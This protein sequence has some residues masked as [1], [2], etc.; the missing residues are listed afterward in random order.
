[1]SLKDIRS[2]APVDWSDPE[3]ASVQARIDVLREISTHTSMSYSE[4]EKLVRK[5][6]S[7]HDKSNAPN[8]PDEQKKTS[9][10]WDI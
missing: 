4:K 8:K 7:I 1:M 9:Q 10:N 3:Q 2:G 5:Q 6:L